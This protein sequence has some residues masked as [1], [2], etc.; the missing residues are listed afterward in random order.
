MPIS[1]RVTSVRDEGEYVLSFGQII[2]SG[3]YPTGGDILNNAANQQQPE[4]FPPSGPAN[5]AGMPVFL[6]GM[7]ALRV[8]RTPFEWNVQMES[9]YNVVLVPGAG[10]FNFKL[11]ILDPATKAELPNGAYPAAITGAVF[12]V[13]E[14]RFKKN[15]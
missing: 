7:T 1:Y 5:T 11:K 6:T 10:P 13:L 4:I 3:N 9:G 12:N 15:I 14:L 2:F 8:S